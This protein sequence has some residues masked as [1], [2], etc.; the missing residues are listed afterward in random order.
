MWHCCCRVDRV[1]FTHLT[2]QE[3]EPRTVKKFRAEP[4]SLCD[5]DLVNL[6]LLHAP[7]ACYPHQPILPMEWQSLRFSFEGVFQDEI[8][9][10]ALPPS[11]QQARLVTAA[12]SA[13]S[14]MPPAMSLPFD[15]THSNDCHT[16]SGEGSPAA[17]PMDLDDDYDYGTGIG[18]GGGGGAD[19]RISAEAVDRHIS[20]SDAELSHDLFPQRETGLERLQALLESEHKWEERIRSLYRSYA[21]GTAKGALGTVKQD[22]HADLMG[23]ERLLDTAVLPV[24]ELYATLNLKERCDHVLQQCAVLESKERYH[25]DADAIEL[26]QLVSLAWVSQPLAKSFKNKNRARVTNKKKKGHC[27]M[28][29]QLLKAPGV[30]FS[31]TSQVTAY[32]YIGADDVSPTTATSA[33]GSG[34]ATRSDRRR[35]T[36]KRTSED[37]A[38][39]MDHRSDVQIQNNV[40]KLAA[41]G[42]VSFNFRFPAGT[43][44]KPCSIRLHV[45]GTVETAD[46]ARSEVDV[47]SEPTHRFIVTTNECQYES[48][49]MKLMAMEIFPVVGQDSCSWSRFVNALNVRWMRVTRQES[50]SDIGSIEDRVLSLDDLR[51]LASRFFT[52]APRRVTY[53][54]LCEFYSFFG[55]V[56][57]IYRHNLAVR[58]LLLEGLIWG[59]VSK[60]TA[61]ERLA[62]MAPGAFLLRVSDAQ[63]GAFAVSWHDTMSGDVRHAR[64]DTKG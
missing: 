13:P 14:R 41:D 15:V 56:T 37:A 27:T 10:A 48:A 44:N 17:R 3:V 12:N 63:P 33:S 20:G 5:A 24:R 45:R 21:P 8:L 2:A 30:R 29:A 59:F 19:V 62:S 64:L 40:E 28:Q 55:K 18:G 9:A 16:E 42:T 31:A 57:H 54:Q 1:L 53:T 11:P 39:S 35:R 46:G 7:P 43:R 52:D 38:S 61:T 32:F 6:D 4:P 34:S 25:E 50:D 23:I 26:Q 58:Q 60:E 49:E 22:V 36:S 51:Y 47:L